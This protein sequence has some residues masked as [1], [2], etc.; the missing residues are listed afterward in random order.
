MLKTKSDTTVRRKI[1]GLG[2]DSVTDLSQ[3]LKPPNI[4]FPKNQEPLELNLDLIDEDPNQPR[5]VFDKTLLQDMAT[6]IVTRGVK[7]PISV[8][9]HPTEEG[10]YIINDGAR[11]YRASKLAEKKTIRAFIDSDFTK[12]DQIIVNAHHQPF[13]AREWAVLIDQELKKG[14]KKSEIA[15]ELGMSRPTITHLAALLHLPDPIALLFNSGRFVDPT[16]LNELVVMWNI[17]AKKVEA[18]LSDPTLEITRAAVRNLHRFMETGIEEPKVD[19]E[20]ESYEKVAEEPNGAETE[21]KTKKEFEQS[22]LRKTIVQVQHQGRAA[23][24]QLSR[25]PSAN[26]QAWLKYD[27]DGKALEVAL[28]QVKLVA[29]LEG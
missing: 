21:N 23:Q 4:D 24:L 20:A 22:K 16:G 18:W 11:R 9:K 3:F 7:N 5:T 28:A 27:D 25:R 17:D 19:N 29:L 2:L 13:T 15:D 8:H 14:K 1:S 10:R 12:I 26:G 6:T